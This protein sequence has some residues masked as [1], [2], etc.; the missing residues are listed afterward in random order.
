[1]AS[2]AAPDSATHFAWRNL[3]S[4]QAG[5]LDVDEAAG[6]PTAA[7]GGGLTVYPCLRFVATIYECLTR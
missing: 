1:M 5:T 3:R 7:A 2:A 4:W 6:R